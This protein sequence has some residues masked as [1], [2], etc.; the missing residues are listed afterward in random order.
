MQ[1]KEDKSENEKH[2][3]ICGSGIKRGNDCFHG[4]FRICGSRIQGRSSGKEDRVQ[5]GTTEIWRLSEYEA[6]GAT[7]ERYSKGSEAVQALKAG[8]IDCVIIDSQRRRNS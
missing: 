8:Q 4:S 7:V 3:K 2:E 6:E 1:A 5:L